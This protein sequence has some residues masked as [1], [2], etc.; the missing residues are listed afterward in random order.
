MW[1]ASRRACAALNSIDPAIAALARS[2]VWGNWTLAEFSPSKMPETTKIEEVREPI[3]Q[4][5]RQDHLNEFM[6]NLQNRFRPEIKDPEFFARP[7][8]IL[9]GTQPRP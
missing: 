1:M 8:A 2:T 7:S 6:M 9:N 5:I 4:Q 3:V